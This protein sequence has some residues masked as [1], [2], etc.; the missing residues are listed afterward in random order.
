MSK[1]K[2]SKQK[3]RNAARKS[4]GASKGHA[5]SIAKSRAEE[6][7]DQRMMLNGLV[8]ETR[9]LRQ[10]RAGLAL[11][12]QA[13]ITS[14]QPMIL[15]QAKQMSRVNIALAEA[16]GSAMAFK[17]LKADEKATLAKI[18]VGLVSVVAEKHPEFLTPASRQ[19]AE[20]ILGQTLE[21]FLA[22]QVEQYLADP[23]NEDVIELFKTANAEHELRQAPSI[24][25]MDRLVAVLQRRDHPGCV[26]DLEY[27]AKGAPHEPGLLTAAKRAVKLIE[28]LLDG[29]SRTQEPG[30]NV[31]SF[32]AA[33]GTLSLGALAESLD[34]LGCLDV[35]I[36]H[37]SFGA[38]EKVLDHLD[39]DQQ[40]ELVNGLGAQ[41]DML[42]FEI[43]A[44]V[45][46][47]DLEEIQELVSDTDQVAS[48]DPVVT[49]RA[50]IEREV[51]FKNITSDIIR[52]KST[53]AVRVLI[54]DYETIESD[55][56]DMMASD[57][58]MGELMGGLMGDDDFDDDFMDEDDDFAW[59]KG[60]GLV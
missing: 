42:H 11:L 19:L 18:I 32:N 54:E 3:K 4:K 38:H 31:I 45:S 43:A 48:F 60:R 16:L 20:A 27:F 56:D 40:S 9:I 34:V 22:E 49:Y 35:L 59:D 57:E 14:Y 7:Q 8:A 30:S 46:H 23:A 17:G 53:Q 10:E 36:S 25:A 21:E 29:L 28:T 44:I 47:P 58:L 39:S 41:K 1:S 12:L 2:K 15:S 33:A 5:T 37:P 50:M 52:N 13:K 55:G 24:R 6:A 51:F 26:G